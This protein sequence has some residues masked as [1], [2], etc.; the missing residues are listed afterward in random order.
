[1]STTDQP[2]GDY[3]SDLGL[4]GPCIR[5]AGHKDAHD[6]GAQSSWLRGTTGGAR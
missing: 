5:E 6:D 1:M 2:C 3:V 4:A